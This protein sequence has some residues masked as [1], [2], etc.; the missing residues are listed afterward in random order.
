V[1]AFH[2]YNSFCFL[3]APSSIVTR[4]QTPSSVLHAQVFGKLCS[5]SGV[6]KRPHFTLLRGHHKTHGFATLASASES[7]RNLLRAFDV[8]IIKISSS[9]DIREISHDVF[10]WSLQTQSKQE[11]PNRVT[12]SNISGGPR[13]LMPTW[14]AMYPQCDGA[15]VCPACK[16][17]QLRMPLDHGCKHGITG[18]VLR[19]LRKSVAHVT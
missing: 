19:A 17:E 8:H 13:E 14:P 2:P 18:E 11:R 1:L 16:W 3:S 7:L 5:S 9:P 15:R 4:Y 6:A 10:K 12:L